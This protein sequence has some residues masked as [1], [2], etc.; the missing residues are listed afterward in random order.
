[1]DRATFAL[2]PIPPYDFELTAGYLAYFRGRYAAD[3][4]ED[5][6]LR[7][8]LDL[9]GRLSLVSV[10]SSGDVESPC[11]EVELRGDALD[12]PAIDGAQRQVA[13]MLSADDNLS[14]FYG[15][16]LAD[17]LLAPFVKGMY[18]LHAA[19]T[20]SVYEA[21]VLAILGQQISTHVARMMRTLLI[22]TYGPKLELDGSTY[23]AF[24]RPEALAAAGVSGLRAIKLSRRKAE[25]I[26]DIA[27]RV[28]S[29]ELD[30]EG[31]RGQPAE[32]AVRALTSIRGVGPWTAHWLLIRA[33]GHGDGFPHGDLAL[34]RILGALANGGAPMSAREAL[35]FSR[36]WSPYRSYVTT[37]LFAAVRSGRFP[38]IGTPL[39]IPQQFSS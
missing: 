12:D 32:D 38:E 4:F 33:L 37:Y 16:A 31:L 27:A 25:Y 3:S 15:M 35:E 28:A 20:T 9:S 11:L 36:R 21:L 2:K 18:G 30:L 10:R 23:Y 1:V 8:L 29:G 34:Q 24:P 26:V 22:E 6:V 39:R 14:P 17:P 5:G 19:H 13:W 7:R